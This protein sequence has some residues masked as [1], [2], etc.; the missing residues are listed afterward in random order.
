[1]VSRCTFIQIYFPSMHT[2]KIIGML[3]EADFP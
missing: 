1:M 2:D 3:M